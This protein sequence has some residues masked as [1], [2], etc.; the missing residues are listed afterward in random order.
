MRHMKPAITALLCGALLAACET[1]DGRKIVTTQPSE[2]VAVPDQHTRPI[3][4]EYGRTLLWANETEDGDVEWFDMTG[5]PISPYKFQ[6]GIGKDT[7]PSIDEPEFVR[8][9]DPRVAERGITLETP[10]LG[11]FIHSIARAYPVD[12]MSMHE[13]VNDDIAGKPYAVMW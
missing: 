13:V 1:M 8:F 3:K 9:G 5:S 2:D 7:I 6:F 10:V 12:L 4:E 11:V